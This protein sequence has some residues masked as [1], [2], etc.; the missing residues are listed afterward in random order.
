M[1][2]RA[3]ENNSLCMQNLG[4]GVGGG[5]VGETKCIMGNSKIEK[6]AELA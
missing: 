2:P 3:L 1:F 4:E 6:A 5:G